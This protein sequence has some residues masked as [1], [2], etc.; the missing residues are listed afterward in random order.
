MTHA[1]AWMNLEDTMLCE[2]SVT[3]GQISYESTYMKY[4]K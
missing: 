4:L 3:K 1:T 2:M